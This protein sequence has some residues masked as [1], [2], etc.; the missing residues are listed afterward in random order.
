[1]SR[2]VVGVSTF[3]LRPPDTGTRGYDATTRSADAVG[4]GS[5]ASAVADGQ[6]D[7]TIESLDREARTVKVKGNSPVRVFLLYY[8][9]DT[10]VAKSGRRS[11]VDEYQNANGADFRSR[12]ATK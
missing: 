1:M 3:R 8:R 12:W 6:F 9:D 5:T 11:R 7:G 4:G 10:T 2:E